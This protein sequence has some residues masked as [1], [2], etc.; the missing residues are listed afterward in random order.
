MWW[1][2]L[3]DLDRS[4]SIVNLSCQYT[5]I[6]CNVPVV[7]PGGAGGVCE[8]QCVAVCA[9]LAYTS[10]SRSPRNAPPQTGAGRQGGKLQGIHDTCSPATQHSMSTTSISSKQHGAPFI[11]YKFR[12]LR[13]NSKGRTVTPLFQFY[14]YSW[15]I[16][17]FHFNKILSIQNIQYEFTASNP[18]LYVGIEWK[19]TK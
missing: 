3:Q 2:L 12:Q 8:T 7:Q 13:D 19:K 18:N 1:Y 11:K 16:Q 10:C 6:D 14:F 5:K 4:A 9:T 15:H 17:Y